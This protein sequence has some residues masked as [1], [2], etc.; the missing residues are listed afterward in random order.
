MVNYLSTKLLF[1]LTAITKEKFIKYIMLKFSILNS[2]IG[3]LY[4]IFRK[5]QLLY[6]GFGEITEKLLAE[7]F[8][9]N[10]ITLSH[11]NYFKTELVEYLQ[12]KRKT[13]NL[14]F[15]LTATAFQKS[16]WEATSKIDYGK[17]KSYGQVAKS[18]G[19][20]KS[21]RA[22][23]NAL[24]SN[25]LPIVIP[26]HRVIRSDG[27]LGGFGAEKGKAIKKQL[28]EFENNNKDNLL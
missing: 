6:T 11:S 28:I 1:Y 21:A 25:P 4:L 16:V 3:S 10:R 23:G 22:V 27:S 17:T 13:F 9:E 12:G 19:N 2:F 26:C 15:K 24:N 7:K 18:I 14:N 5:Q 20:P 8:P